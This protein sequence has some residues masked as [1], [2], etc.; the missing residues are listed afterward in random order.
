M[1]DK[2]SQDTSYKW[3]VTWWLFMYLTSQMLFSSH[4]F[5]TSLLRQRVLVKSVHLTRFLPTQPLHA[6]SI[7]MSTNNLHNWGTLSWWVC[8]TWKSQL[9]VLFHILGHWKHGIRSMFY[10]WL[11]TCNLY[12]HAY[13]W[14]Y[15]QLMC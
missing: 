1:E 10:D 2:E 14:V 3:M 15:F 8:I 6:S 9:R 4:Y 11:T 12:I 7:P 13:E 5:E